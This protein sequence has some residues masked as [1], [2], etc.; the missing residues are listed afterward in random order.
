LTANGVFLYNAGT[1]FPS[2]G[3]T[4][5][6][7]SLSGNGSVDMSPPTTGPYAGL[8]LFQS[9]DNAQPFSVTGN[10]SVLKV[11]GTLYGPRMRAD[12]SGQNTIP[13]QIIVDTL[14]ITGQGSLDA[15]YNPSQVYGVAT[16][17]L[18]E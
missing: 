1:S 12:I 11:R 13:A 10:M 9:R 6:G 14:K 18:V 17:A 3:G 15:E 7:V 8:M 2:A 5:G 16:T 4:F